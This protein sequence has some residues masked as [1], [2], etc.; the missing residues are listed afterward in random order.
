MENVMRKNLFYIGGSKG[1]TGKSLVTMGLID[2]LQR[3]YEQDEILLFETDTTNPDVGR[4]FKKT[5]GV[6]VENLALNEDEDNWANLIDIIDQSTAPH[7]VVNSM[8]GANL[9]VE[10]RGQFLNEAIDEGIIDVNFRCLWIMNKDKD[11]VDLLRQ[12]MERI[13][14]AI[15]YPIKN[16]WFGK[17]VD[18]TYYHDSNEGRNIHDMVQKRGGRDFCLPVLNSKLTHRLYTEQLSFADIR[19]DITGGMR[20]SLS[21]WISQVSAIFENVMPLRTQKERKPEPKTD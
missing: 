7:I 20:L 2:Y 10:T 3:I 13:R 9:G 16:L 6:T 8:A 4:L 1:G 11:S 14:Y 17:E 15:V 12:Y 19:E 18:F 21:H 5:K